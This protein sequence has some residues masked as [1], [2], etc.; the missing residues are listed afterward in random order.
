[1]LNIRDHLPDS[2]M[3]KYKDELPQNRMWNVKDQLPQ[4][5]AEHHG[6]VTTESDSL[7]H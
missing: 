4:L 3:L 5:D 1:M 6:P 7:L 2:W